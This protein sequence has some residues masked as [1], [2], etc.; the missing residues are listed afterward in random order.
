MTSPNDGRLLD[1]AAVDRLVVEHLPM[2][3]RLAQRLTDDADLAEDLVQEALC[4]VLRQWKS[5]RG[6]SKFGTWMLQVVVNTDRDRRRRRQPQQSIDALEVSSGASSASE[7]MATEELAV[8]IRQTIDQLPDRQREVA[9]VCLGEGLAA[10][11]AAKVLETTP[12]NI[13][14]C[15]HLAR[16]RIAEAIGFAYVA[17]K[18]S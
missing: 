1:R 13:H 15:L 3:L 18:K 9:I 2:A 4:R 12:A 5:F 10:S 7:R 17:A 6:D 14:A 11:E 8:K 16:K